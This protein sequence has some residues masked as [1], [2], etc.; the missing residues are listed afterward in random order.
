MVKLSYQTNIYYHAKIKT[1]HSYNNISFINILYLHGFR[2]KQHSSEI[3][4]LSYKWNF[5]NSNQKR[6]FSNTIPTCNLFL[7]S[8]SIAFSN[9]SKQKDRKGITEQ[10]ITAERLFFHAKQKSLKML[11]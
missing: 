8:S 3:Y 5:S 4:F 7:C 6:V 11:K 2:R 1:H 10:N 9:A